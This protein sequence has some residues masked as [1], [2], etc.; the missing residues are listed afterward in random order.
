MLANYKGLFLAGVLGIAAVVGGCAKDEP[1]SYGKQRRPVDQLD[2]A[3]R[4]LQSKDVVNASDRMAMEL[5]ADER[6]RQSNAKWTMVVMPAEDRT[7]DRRFSTNYDIFIERLRTNLAQRG[8]NTVALIENK[9]RLANLRNKELDG[10]VPS[11][12]PRIQPD[13]ALYA[14]VRDMPNRNTNYYLVQFT[15][16]DLRTGEQVWNGMY[17]VQVER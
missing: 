3:N 8:K 12:N 9:A 10:P 4:G 2:E 5:L 17:E 14:A 11:N 7:I 13:F 1:H 16:T 15:A 6:L